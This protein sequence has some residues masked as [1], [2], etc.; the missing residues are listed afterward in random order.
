[1][2]FDLD[3]IIVKIPL[4]KYQGDNF[5]LGNYEPDKNNEISFTTRDL[6]EQFG[7]DVYETKEEIDACLED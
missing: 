1:M 6:L 5:Y 7:Y 2:A 4:D 3:S